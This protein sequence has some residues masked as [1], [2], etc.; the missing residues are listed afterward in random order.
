MDD[1]KLELVRVEDAPSIVAIYAHYV[2]KT[3]WSF[4]LCPPT[5][6]GAARRIAVISQ[7]YPYIVAKRKEEI[8]AYCYAAWQCGHNA[9][10]YNAELA[11]YI[12]PEYIG[13]GIGKRLYRAEIEILK[14]QNIKT[15]YGLVSV[16]NERSVALHESMGFEQTS[17][18]SNMGFKLGRWY[19]VA[20]YK[21]QIGA[22]DETPGPVRNII[23]VDPYMIEKILISR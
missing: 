22:Y 4:E 12:K 21:K 2:E 5:A 15:V 23:D 8:I 6:E 19:D 3:I 14:L 18:V 1:I 7:R 20:R 13:Q 10:E 16:P 17:Y 9:L 11:I